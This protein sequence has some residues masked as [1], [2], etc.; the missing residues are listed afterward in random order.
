MA[1]KVGETRHRMV[2]VD[3]ATAHR[4]EQRI[5]SCEHCHPADAEITFDWLLPE[6]TG[7]RGASLFTLP[8][9]TVKHLTSG[10]DDRN[11]A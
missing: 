1:M 3:P 2:T 7:K 8:P 9:R 5:E 11:T 4:V 10:A 6:V